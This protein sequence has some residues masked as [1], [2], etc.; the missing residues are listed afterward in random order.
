MDFALTQ[1]AQDVQ[2]AVG[3]WVEKQAR[4]GRTDAWDAARWQSFVSLGLIDKDR[5]TLFDRCVGLMEGA[6]AGLP[7]P[8]LEAQL[9][10]LADRSG[11]AQEVLARGGVL[12]SALPGAAGPV[13]VGWGGVAD[14]VVDQSTGK[15]VA[16]AALPSGQ[17]S[18]PVPHGWLDRVAASVADAHQVSRWMYGAVL[19]AGLCEGALELTSEYVRVRE[20]FGRTLASFQAVQFPLAEVK[21]LAD[22]AR[23]AALDAVLRVAHGQPHAG[24]QSALAWLAATQAAERVTRV[25]HQS[26]GATGF[27]YETGLVDLTWAMSWLRLSIG[28]KGAQKF[29]TAA[30]RIGREERAGQ[31]P[32]CL[33]LE[34]FADV[35]NPATVG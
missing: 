21:M 19:L 5:D 32:H 13:L 25:T 20:Q 31:P 4:K 8:V 33:V 28:N 18:Y 23:F 29:L 6:R 34:G 26:F 7:G 35:G 9:A 12:S 16:E 14:L 24:V 3:R 15:V 27:C 22:G 17:F 1:T 2:Q 30:R 11:R 10:L